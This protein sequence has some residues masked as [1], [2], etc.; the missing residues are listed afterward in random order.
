MSSFVLRSL[1]KLGTLALIEDAPNDGEGLA[2][3]LPEI[4]EPRQ[5]ER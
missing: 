3:T 4:G 5:G 2:A 1:C